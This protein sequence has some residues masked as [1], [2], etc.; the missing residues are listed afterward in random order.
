VTDLAGPP[1]APGGGEK[2]PSARTPDGMHR[3]LNPLSPLIAAVRVIPGVVLAIIIFGASTVA[4]LGWWAVPVAVM[5][6]LAVAAL[7]AVFSY[8][9]WL[10]LDYWFDGSGDLRI[11]SGVINRNERKLALSRLQA[12]DVEQP[13]VARL[14]GLAIVKIEVAGVGE[15]K[16]V[17]SYLT[18]ADAEQLRRE[19]LSRAAK[20]AHEDALAAPRIE[21]ETVIARVAPGDLALSLL[22]RSAT[23]GL[24]ALTVLLGVSA[25]LTDGLVGV[26]LMPFTAGIPILMVGTE[27]ITYYGFTVSKAGGGLRLRYGLLST[28]AQFV[29]P[30]RVQAIDFME[31]L[32]WRPKGWVR[33]R[34]TVAGMGQPSS[35]GGGKSVARNVLLPVATREEAI[36]MFARILPGVD[37]AAIQWNVAPTKARW[38]SPI[39]GT[40]LAYGWSD[41]VLVTRRGMIT[42]YLSVVPHARTQSVRVVQGPYQRALGLASTYVDVPPGPVVVAALNQLEPDA[43]RLAQDQAQRAQ[44]ARLG[45]AH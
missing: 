35:D 28:Q 27:F 41:Q 9:A 31:P 24:L 17:L 34:L 16:A 12:I 39:Q 29:P 5:L 30:G 40:R 43:A 8:L 14:V 25:F 1:P 33:M 18:K 44:T 37:L 15:Q 10:R 4:Q 2:N 20:E 45:E 23:A 21:A 7:V 11:D 6:A 3:K 26:M 19:I 38:R 22:I 42:R 13:L 32:L 36:E